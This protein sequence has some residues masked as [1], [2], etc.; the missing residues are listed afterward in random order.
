MGSRARS[1]R[2][3]VRRHR[4]AEPPRAWDAVGQAAQAGATRVSAPGAVVGHYHQDV[5][6]VVGHADRRRARARVPRDVGETLA[7]M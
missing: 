3:C 1:R 6:A 5:A 2:R 4:A 7:Q